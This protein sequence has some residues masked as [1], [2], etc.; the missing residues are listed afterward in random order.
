MSVIRGIVGVEIAGE[1]RKLVCD[2]LAGQEM[3]TLVG[4][5]WMIWLYERFIGAKV[6]EIRQCIPL[7][8]KDACIALYAMLAADREDTG[9]G[10]ES[11][12]SLM[13][14]ISPLEQGRLYEALRD[15]VLASLGV[16]GKE[17][18]DAAAAGAPP[19]GEAA[20]THG[21]GTQL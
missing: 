5:H 20:E 2:M 7:S 9:R 18:G 8:P 16:P 6:G 14:S 15:A 4:E 17:P 19:S 1:K 11:V 10:A 13:R 12:A 21:T 3:F